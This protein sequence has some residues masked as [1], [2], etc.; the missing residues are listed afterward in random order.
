MENEEIEE[1]IV[2]DFAEHDLN[3]IADYYFS[4]SP[5]YVERIISEFEENVMSLQDILSKTSLSSSLRT[6]MTA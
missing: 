1:I 3:E 2:S 6:M 4:R 5:D